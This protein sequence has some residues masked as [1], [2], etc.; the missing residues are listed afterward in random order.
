MPFGIVA[1]I[2]IVL[3]LSNKTTTMPNGEPIIVSESDYNASLREVINLTHDG[4]ANFNVGQEIDGKQK[5]D[6]RKA[7]R[8]LDNMNVFKQTEAAGYF[9]SGLLNYIVGN[10]D[11][12]NQQIQQA[13]ANAQLVPNLKSK[14]DQANLEG[15]IGDAHHILSLIFFD[16]HD[17]QT[18]LKEVDEALKHVKRPNI[19]VARARINLELSK[20]DPKKKE[21]AQDDINSALSMDP[22]CPLALKLNG[23][24]SQ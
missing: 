10:S 5:D 6:I 22:N 18:A 15:V 2:L 19:F 13:L 17:Y 7:I 24:M 9:E 11:V 23:F 16:K 12:A 1:V 14:T 21:S 4:V 20:T 3:L 8:I